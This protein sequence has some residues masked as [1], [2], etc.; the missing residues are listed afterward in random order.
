MTLAELERLALLAE[1]AAEVIQ[2]VGKII[3]HGYESYH[4]NDPDTTNRM[5][6]EKELGHLK[7]AILL[8]DLNKDVDR[9]NISQGQ[10]DKSVYCPKYLHHQACVTDI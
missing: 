10:V 2:I 4:P 9:I 3:R 8:M 1:E 6:L 5:L 7:Y